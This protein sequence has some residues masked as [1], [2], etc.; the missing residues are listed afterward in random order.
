M[1]DRRLPYRPRPLS[2]APEAPYFELASAAEEGRLALYIGA[3]V[4]MG[5]PSLL[6][7]SR[8]LLETLGPQVELNLGIAVEGVDGDEQ[9]TLETLAD[10]AEA[11]NLLGQLQQ[12]A[13]KAKPFGDAPPNYGHRVVA[14][15]IREGAT[16]VFSVNW[17]RCVETGSAAL[18]FYL[19]A[20]I[21]DED[22]ARRFSDTRFHKVHGC[23]SQPSSLLISTQQ[24][25]TPPAWVE[26]EVGAAL[27][28]STVVFVGLG[29]V[30]GYIRRRVEQVVSVLGDLTPVWLAD[31]YPSRTWNE[32]LERAGAGHV[33]EV[34]ANEFFDSLISAFVRRMLGHLLAAA[35]DMDAGRPELALTP[36]MQR[37]EGVLSGVPALDVVLWLRLGGGG[38]KSGLPLIHS[39]ESRNAFLALALASGDASFAVQ[40][41]GNQLALSAGEAFIEFAIWP[42]T[43]ADEVVS[44]EMAR[45]QERRSHGCY[46][47]LTWPIFHICV[48]HRGDLPLPGM[49]MDIIG[50]GDG[51]ELLGGGV[52]HYWIPADSAVQGQDVPQVPVP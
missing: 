12:L 22:R 24:L 51:S 9:A 41:R 27:G 39:Q 21:T 6:P 10:L 45:F 23:C 16:T 14:A 15:L 8:E 42:E 1:P 13:A 52:E 32:L 49:V 50:E 28:A 11:E 35:R 34:G 38:V 33:L 36:A 48:G 43:R 19:D 46:R 18:G 37:L 3:G 20:T 4:S 40:L 44:R 2:E 7:T 30:G 47:S 31:P 26:H 29:T 25:E 5:S 17:D